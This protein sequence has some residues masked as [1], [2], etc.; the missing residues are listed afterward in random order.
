VAHAL[1]REGPGRE[2]RPPGVCATGGEPPALLG[3][4]DPDH[5]LRRAW[6]GA[7]AREGPAGRAAA[8]LVPDG[9]GNP[10]HKHEGFPR[11]RDLPG[12]RQAGAARDRHHGHLRRQ[13]WY[14]M[15]YCDPTNDQAMVAEGADYWMPMD[16]YIGG[17]EHAILH[18]LYARFWTK[19]MRDLGLV[20]VDEPFTKLLTQGMVLN[21]IYSRKG[22]KGGIEY[23]W[24]HEVEDVLTM[25]Q[26]HRRPAEAG[27]GRPA[28]RHPHHYE[29]VGTMSK[30]KNNGVDP[31]DLIE[32]YGADTARLY[33]MFTAPPEATLE[34]NDAAVEGSY[35]FLRRV[36][37]F[38]VK[39][40]ATENV[41][42]RQ[43]QALGSGKKIVEFGKN[44]KA[45]RLEIHTVLKQVDYDYQR[46]Q[47]NTVVSGAMKMLNALETSSPTAPGDSVA[48][49]RGLWHPAALPVPGHAA[50]H[51]C[52]VA[53]AGLCRRW[54]TARR[55]LARGRPEALKQDEIELMLQVN[56]KLRGAIRVPARPTRR[57]SRRLRWPTRPSSS[58]PPGAIKKV[59]VV[60]GRL[61]NVVVRLPISPSGPSTSTRAPPLRWPTNCGAASRRPTR[62]RCSW[63]RARWPEQMWCWTCCR[64]CSEKV[65]VAQNSSGQVQ[66]FQLRMT[67]RFRLRTPAGKELIADAELLQQRDISFSESAVLAKEAEGVIA[68]PQTC[69]LNSCSRSC[70]AGG[71]EGIMRC[72]WDRPQRRAARQLCP[73]PIRGLNAAP[74]AAPS[75]GFFESPCNLLPP[76][77]PPI[78]KKA[79]AAVHLHGDEPLLIQEAADAIRAAAPAQGFTERTV[80][81]VAGAHFDW[82]EVLAAGGSLSLFAERQIVEIRIPSGKPG[83][84]GS[85]AIQ[86]LA[87]RRAATTARCCVVLPR[88]DK[89]TRT[90]PGSSRWNAGVTIRSTRWSARRCRSGSRSACSGRASA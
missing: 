56:G 67:V 44:A 68:V 39:L 42:H 77:S 8:G 5:P 64:A 63:T 81:T 51:P 4:A 28:R 34:W 70:C 1:A 47:Y 33:T 9:S 74:R 14:F 85:V 36:W 52:A 45:L 78:S 16:Q 66:E 30:S 60:P 50:H 20:K 40:E 38:G 79:C 6:R 90:A 23:F 58:R 43:R 46:M 48:A 26:G 2:R 87:E 15:R 11:R 72:L 10:L 25:R 53:G 18:L 71:G 49:G 31:Q 82:S 61:V 12:L 57:R 88:L 7:G 29:G 75:L 55:A 21:H 76:S 22:E 62:C 59:I 27:Q 13:S 86:Q 89:A 17:I 19:V 3:H 83:K 73:Q 84:D 35:R 37:N 24:P 54:A 32:K 69:S 65:V 41:A 80:H